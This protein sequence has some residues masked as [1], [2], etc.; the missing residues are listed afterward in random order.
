M[1]EVD[2]MMKMIPTGQQEGP[3]PLGRHCGEE[4]TAD[5]GIGDPKCF[6]RG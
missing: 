5:H 3:P 6:C 4:S 1:R 2:R